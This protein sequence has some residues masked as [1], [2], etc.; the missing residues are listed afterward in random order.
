VENLL[1]LKEGN[2]KPFTESVLSVDSDS[3]E[4]L[5]KVCYNLLDELLTAWFGAF[6][7]PASSF[8]LL[9]SFV[10]YSTHS[11]YQAQKTLSA[12]KVCGS[13]VL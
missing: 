9:V 5:S 13:L 10:W 11:A 7:L 1:F 3:R 12:D 6:L 2:R 4:V 8:S